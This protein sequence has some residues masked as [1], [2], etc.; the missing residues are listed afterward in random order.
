MPGMRF[1]AFGG[2]ALRAR[3]RTFSLWCCAALSIAGCGGGDDRAAAGFAPFVAAR[4][5]LAPA[6]VVSPDL[7]MRWAE[8]V[9]PDLFAPPGRPTQFATPYVYRHYPQS[10][11]YLGVAGQD[12]FVRGAPVGSDVPVRIGSLSDYQCAVVPASCWEGAQAV[13]IR[14]APASLYGAWPRRSYVIRNAQELAAQWAERQDVG[15]PP[16]VPDI[17]FSTYA[18]V[19]GSD[20]WSNTACGGIEPKLIL[21]QGSDYRVLWGTSWTSPFE[22]CLQMISPRIAFVLVPQPVGN[23]EFVEVPAY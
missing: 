5:Q 18:V 3:A 23:V 1:A 22:A 11:A 2:S 20:G 14:Y 12:I 7:L 4:Q 21:R 9:R 13:P 19:G 10:D 8:S 17:D 15:T 16:P 6:S